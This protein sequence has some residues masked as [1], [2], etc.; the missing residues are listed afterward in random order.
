MLGDNLGVEP[1]SEVIFEV[2]EKEVVDE[3]VSIVASKLKSTIQLEQI[4]EEEVVE[5]KAIR[6]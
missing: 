2:R 5:G 4:I 3:Y 1:E 6:R